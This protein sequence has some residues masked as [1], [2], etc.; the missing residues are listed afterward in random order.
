MKRLTMFA[1]LLGF[2]T[3]L[4]ISA[5]RKDPAKVS[6]D[7]LISETQRSAEP[8]DG[9]NM[10][11]YIPTEF[12]DVVLRQDPTL[13]EDGRKE[14]I[15]LLD[16]YFILGVV[17]AD[18]SQ[19]GTFSFHGEQAVKNAL[20]VTFVDVDGKKQQLKPAAKIPAD[21]QNLLN[22]MRPIFTQAIGNMGQ[23]FHMIVYPDKTEAGKR[24]VSPYEHGKLVVDMAKISKEAG[25][26]VEFALPLDALF[27]PRVCDRCDEEAHIAWNFCPFCGAKLEE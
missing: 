27:E 23:N 20:T 25:G 21:M 9:M 11:W 6:P 18:I 26:K 24:I 4:A 22:A 19:F 10:V 17:R 1:V 14:M 12:W 13:S 16:D 8:T 5:E 7:K 2:F 3:G 15:D